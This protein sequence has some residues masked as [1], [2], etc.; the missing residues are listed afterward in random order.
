MD[1][2][3]QGEMYGAIGGL[4]FAILLMLVEIRLRQVSLR[5]LSAAVF[6]LVFG[7]FVAWM[8]TRILSLT[9][10]DPSTLGIIQIVFT[11]VFCYLGMTISIK[12]KDEFNLIIPYVRF[13]REEQDAKLFIVDTSVIIDGRIT[14]ICESGFVSGKLII[15]RFVLAELQGIADSSDE[16]KRVRGRRG[17]NML[18]N[19][20]KVSGIEVIVHD[21]DLAHIKEV[22]A[23]LIR[24]AKML[25]CCV[26]TNDFNL[27]KVAKI[28]GITTLNVNGL[29]DAMRLV[30][31]P[32]DELHVYVRKEGKEK[33]QGVA[34]LDDGTMIVVDN[35]RKLIGKGVNVTVTS[36][37][38]TSAGR[39]IF[40]NIIESR[41]GNR[42]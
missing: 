37:L 42:P 32:G 21:E 25:G 40:A 8:L 5:N 19:L 35:A 14:G 16:A 11:L 6:G 23:K 3:P 15:P 36:V 2:S 28:E 29:A 41:N 26:L 7:F 38:Q 30:I 1:F 4:M 10:M 17:L 9:Q 22:D 31:S 12:G 33:N 27:S 20:K 18:E 39:M 13:S 24:L 34:F